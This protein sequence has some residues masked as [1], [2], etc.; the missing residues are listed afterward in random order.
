MEIQEEIL[1][2]IDVQYS[3]RLAKKMEQFYSNEAL[4]FRTAGSKAEFD[5]GEML[6]KEMEDIGLSDVKKEA[7]T[8]DGWEFKKAV[9]CFTGKDGKKKQIQLGA[10][11][12]SFVTQGFQEFSLV[13]IGRGTE[14]DYRGRDV[15]GKLVLADI[16]QRDEWWI[17][18]PV[19]QAYLKGAA[20][21][22]AVQAGGYGEIDHKA[23]NAQDIACLLYTS[24]C[25]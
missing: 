17:N 21:L 3:Y 5:T 8:V 16:N 9:L 15:K 6:K 7:V 22:L 19:Y 13:Y 25:V 2:Y 11:Q 14:E 10:Y 4:G 1:K 12:T 24:R 18:Y 20:G 23:L